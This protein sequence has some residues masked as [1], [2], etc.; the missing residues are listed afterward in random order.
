MLYNLQRK[1]LYRRLL[2]GGALCVAGLGVFSCSDKYDLDTD[3][4]SGL[5]SIYGYMEKKG[6]FKNYLQLIQDLGQK[7]ILS[8]TGSKTLFIADDDAFARFF[9]SNKWGV[10]RYEDLTLAQK[11]LLLNTAT[12]D[13]PYSTSMLSTAAGSASPIT[14]EVLR[15]SSSSSLLDSVLLVP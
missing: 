11:K 5:N 12:I 13:N 4:P 6:N 10:K 2:V 9:Q 14:G 7:D 3:Q 15:R 1:K 8:K